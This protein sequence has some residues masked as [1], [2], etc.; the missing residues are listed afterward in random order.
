MNNRELAILSKLSYLS[1]DKMSKLYYSRPINNE[2]NIIYN[3]DDMPELCSCE[4]DSQMYIC[5]L[6]NKIIF[7][8]RGTE[9][10][11]D[12]LTNINIFLT[13]LILPHIDYLSYPKIHNGF[14]NQF[15][16]LKDKIDNNIDNMCNKEIY[17]TGHSLGGAL[18]TIASLYYSVKYKKLNISCITFGSPRVGNERFTY[19]FDVY[20]KK[21]YRYINR[22]D[23]IP[24][25]PFSKNFNHVKGCLCLEDNIIKTEMNKWQL[26]LFI[27]NYLLSFIG[28]GYDTSKD[29]SCEYYIKNLG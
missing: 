18:A 29:H 24:C 7:V 19:L 26:Y 13:D 12:I 1:A 3:L 25:I 11:L 14:Y 15:L 16:G 6:K 27:K 4:N 10:K 8:F 28:L 5:N 22:Y 2:L 17:F 20:V 23:P 21:S 9:S